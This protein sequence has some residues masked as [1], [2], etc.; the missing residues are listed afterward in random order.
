MRPHDSHPSP[1]VAVP[2]PRPHRLGGPAR[3]TR[4][5]GVSAVAGVL[6]SA[7]LT[8]CVSGTGA[9]DA[10]AAKRLSPPVSAS[11]LWPYG[12]AKWSPAQRVPASRPKPYPPVRGVSVP[13]HGGLGKVPART[14][15]AR[16][17]SVPGLIHKAM[18]S[19]SDPCCSLRPPVHRDLTGDGRDELIIAVDVLEAHQTLLQVYRAA[20]GEIRPI[21]VYWGEPELTGETVGRDL[22]L[23]AT[24]DNVLYTTRYR[25]N[26][27][28]LTAVSDEP[29]E[30]PGSGSTDSGGTGDSPGPAPPPQP[31]AGQTRS[32]RSSA[33][34]T[35]LSTD[36]PA[37]F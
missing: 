1:Q 20:A 15:L 6:L 29:Q 10:G 35:A 24:G 36:R 14:L 9:R 17:P 5:L 2:P 33:S 31:S 12:V 25:W 27:Q 18:L 23:T 28:V 7:V 34:P 3:T 32:S 16:D 13:P 19:R 21:F 37:A 4:A 22:V 11:P 30:R 8:G 26:G